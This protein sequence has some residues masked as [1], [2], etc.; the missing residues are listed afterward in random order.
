MVQMIWPD[1]LKRLV[2]GYVFRD[3]V[4]ELTSA[5]RT[6]ILVV[7]KQGALRPI[8]I[9]PVRERR[10]Y[11]A[12]LPVVL[13]PIYASYEATTR[14]HI[15]FCMM[16]LFSESKILRDAPS[17]DSIDFACEYVGL[18]HYIVHSYVR[19]TDCVLSLIA[20]GSNRYDNEL[21]TAQRAR[22][23]AEYVESGR[24]HIQSGWSR[25]ERFADWWQT[26]CKNIPRDDD[27][28]AERRL[29]VHPASITCSILPRAR[30]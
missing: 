21:N 11:L 18:G 29:A 23:I 28:T 17:S 25:C 7:C 27:A 20:G 9:K 8:Q 30:A 6:H 1:D 2:F 3:E 14:F 4:R 5:L 15:L 19:K 26:K 10:K 24:F 12:Q 13:Q 16:Q 22:T